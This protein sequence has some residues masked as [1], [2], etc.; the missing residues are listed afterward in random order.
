MKKRSIRVSLFFIY[1]LLIG[2]NNNI[3]AFSIT[4]T[5]PSSGFY[6]FG[7]D[8]TKGEIT[9]WDIRVHKNGKIN[10]YLMDDG[11]SSSFSRGNYVSLVTYHSVNHVNITFQAPYSDRFFFVMTSAN[12]VSQKVTLTKIDK[13]I[14]ISFPVDKIIYEPYLNPS[15]CCISWESS[16]TSNTVDLILY[17]GDTE[18]ETI[19]SSTLDDG[20]FIWEIPLGAYNGA[21]YQMKVVDSSDSTIYDFT[22]YFSIYNKKSITIVKPTTGNSIKQGHRM[23]IS[24]E[25]TSDIEFVNI[26]LYKGNSFRKILISGINASDRTFIWKVPDNLEGTNFYIKIYDYFNEYM[27]DNSEYFTIVNPFSLEFVIVSIT[28][29]IAGIILIICVYIFLRRRKSRL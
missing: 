12:S 13:W 19:T 26:S 3:W 20:K 2:F 9:K 22:P 14:Y 1:L 8:L 16:Q 21:D 6:A 29:P 4:E 15:N 18:L 25:C 27:H 23:E 28:L 11:N 24:W 17:K 10:I 5:V 7:F